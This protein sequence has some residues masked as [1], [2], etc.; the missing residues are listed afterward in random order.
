MAIRRLKGHCTGS[1]ISCGLATRVSPQHQQ[2]AAQ[3]TAHNRIR[4]FRH[5]RCYA[6]TTLRCGHAFVLQATP[7][8]LVSLDVLSKFGALGLGGASA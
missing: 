1:I 3:S 6:R 8:A 2:A 5:E 7:E 4:T